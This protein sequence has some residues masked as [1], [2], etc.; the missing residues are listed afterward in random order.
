MYID[1]WEL[2]RVADRME[3]RIS[4]TD[5]MRRVRQRERNTRMLMRVE[6]QVLQVF[7]SER[8]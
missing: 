2:G 3:R 8:K 7:V 6:G 5:M 1:K 4:S